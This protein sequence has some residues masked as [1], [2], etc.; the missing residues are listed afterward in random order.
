MAA[1]G[2]PAELGAADY[3]TPNDYPQMP[4]CFRPSWQSFIFGIPNLVSH[5]HDAGFYSDT[6]DDFKKQRAIR[7][8]TTRRIPLPYRHPT[9]KYDP[10]R[11]LPQRQWTSYTGG[12]R[13]LILNT[14]LTFSTSDRK[15]FTP[16][17]PSPVG[18]IETNLDISIS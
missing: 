11:G 3:L 10:A 16:S 2:E 5:Q 17:S 14:Q 1:S 8:E 15:S 12:D 4:G 6:I 7:D 13:E 9:C 18:I